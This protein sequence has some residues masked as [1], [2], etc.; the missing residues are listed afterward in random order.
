MAFPFNFPCEELAGSPSE[1]FTSQGLTVTRRFGIPW[2]NRYTFYNDMKLN[3]F[4]AP[5]SYPAYAWT[6]VQDISFEPQGAP[7]GPPVDGG[8]ILNPSTTL[9][10]YPLCDGKRWNTIATVV[11][12]PLDIDSPTN[13][14][15]EKLR[16]GTYATWTLGWSGEVQ[17]VPGRSTYY[18]FAQQHLSEVA[19][20]VG[21]LPEDT[22]SGFNVTYQDYQVTWHH[23]DAVALDAVRPIINDLSG[24]VNDQDNYALPGFG[25]T[26]GKET[27]LF[28]GAQSEG[29][30]NTDF[31]QT[32]SLT[33]T[34]RHRNPK[35]LSMNGKTV[36]GDGQAFLSNP[37]TWPR[38]PIGWNHVYIGD[39][40]YAD[41]INNSLALNGCNTEVSFFWDR[42]VNKSG[43]L[44]YELGDFDALFA[45]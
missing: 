39:E 45:P 17:T 2:E 18:Q 12:K 16:A 13:E 1:S 14:E 27:L 40:V 44:N 29:T 19:Q 42:V 5:T 21:K 22:P 41:S 7:V 33:Y 23:I 36:D 20:G 3:G 4:Y 31:T 26:F 32:R 28:M 43:D 24:K 9:P 34:F 10:G 38:V 25:G 6:F 8:D 15:Q 11:Y 35:N 30:M 37:C